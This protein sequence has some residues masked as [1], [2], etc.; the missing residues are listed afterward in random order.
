[1]KEKI[2]IFIIVL[3][4]LSLTFVVLY[5]YSSNS[6]VRSDNQ[7]TLLME[8]GDFC[9]GVAEKSIANR[10]AI[11]EF[12]VYEILGDKAMIMKTCMEDQGFEENPIWIKEASI[13]TQ[14]QPQENQ[15]S[16]DEALEN[17]KHKAIYIFTNADN[18]PLY[19]RSKKAN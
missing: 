15:V 8:K 6:V 10:Q 11:V 2:W 4:F 13:V 19:W 12:Q 17:L 18:K 3:G 7:R 5:F 1:M 9:L 14:K 16:Q